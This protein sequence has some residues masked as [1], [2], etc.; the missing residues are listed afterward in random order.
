MKYAVERPGEGVKVLVDGPYGGINLVR[1]RDADHVLVIA[2][3]SGAGWCLP[4]IERFVRRD[5]HARGNENEAGTKESLQVESCR[6][7]A[8]RVVLATRDIASRTWFLGAVDAL[9]EKYSSTS[10][11]RVQVYL[12]GTAASEAHDSSEN[13]SS[14]NDA[15]ETKLANTQTSH[16]PGREYEGRPDL[17]SIITEE[18][19]EGA[20]SLSVFVCGPT[21]MLNDTRNA[22]AAE[23]LRLMKGKGGSGVYLHSEHFSWA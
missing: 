20:Q 9:L 3:G 18:A 6:P 17:A 2:G 1:F 11:F 21:T 23:N 19:N 4:F 5:M 10:G 15:I 8:L 14:V 16:I 22:V 13:A 7:V 12:T